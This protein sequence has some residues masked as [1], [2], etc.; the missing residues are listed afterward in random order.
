MTTT[1][2][3]CKFQ[4]AYNIKY[5]PIRHSILVQPHGDVV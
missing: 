4:R 3:L 5:A 2:E 1:I